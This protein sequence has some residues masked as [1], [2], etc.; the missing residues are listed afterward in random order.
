MTGEIVE[1]RPGVRTRLLAAAST[2]ATQLCLFEQWSEPGRG[3]PA[4]R[5]PGVE[6][7]VSV[8]AGEAE[9]W[10]EDARRHL[11]AGDTVVVPPDRRHGFTNVGSSILHTLAVFADPAPPVVY[12]TEPDVVLEVGG[13]G[14]DRRDAHRS[15]RSA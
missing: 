5:H 10:V 6:E 1:W 3:A 7:A 13:S 4:H 8:L 15:I 14:A 12:D 11:G 9:L 2:G